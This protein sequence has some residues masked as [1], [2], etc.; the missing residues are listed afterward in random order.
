M[1][2]AAV[3]SRRVYKEQMIYRLYFTALLPW[4]MLAL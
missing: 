4:L 2:T 1:Q 3:A